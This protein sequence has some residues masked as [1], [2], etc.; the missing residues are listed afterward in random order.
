MI[1]QPIT[2]ALGVL[3]C[4]TS[5]V[6]QDYPV[7]AVAA[8]KVQLRDMFWAPR[9]ET[10]RGV[11]IPATFHKNEE[12]GRVRNFEIAAGTAHGNVCTVF[13]FDDTDLYKTIEGVAYFLQRSPNAALVQMVEEWIRLIGEAQEPDGYLYTWRTIAERQQAAGNPD[14]PL[15][16]NAFTDWLGSARWEKEDELSHELYNAG[17][18]YEAAVAWFQATGQRTL[19]DIAL[20]N[21][22]LLY[23]TFGPQKLQKAPGHEVVEM[24]LVQL[25]RA[26]GDRRWLALSKFFIDVRGYGEEYAQNHLPVAQQRSAVGHAVRL[27]YL[28]SGVADIKALTGTTAYDDALWAVWEDIVQR[29]IYLTGG[30]GATGRNEGFGSPYELPNLSAYCETCSSI[31]F[32]QWTQ[33]L[34]QLTGDARYVDVLERTMY[35]A[36]NA[37]LSL[38]GDYFFYPNPLESRK[39]VARSQ[40]F[41]CACCPPNLIRFFGSLP[42]YMYAVDSS[43]IYVNLY[44]A[45]KVKTGL[46]GTSSGADSVTI[47]QTTAFPRDGEISLSMELSRSREFSLRLRI[48][49]WAAEEAIPGNLYQFTAPLREKVA[50]KVNGQSFSTSLHK[51]YIEIRRRWKKGDQVWLS[52]PMPVRRVVADT[53]VAADRGRVAL[54]RGPLVYCL[55]GKD[56]P[57]DRVQ[58]VFLSDTAH[59]Q[60]HYEGG[61]LGGVTALSMP[62][63]LVHQD[64]ETAIRLEPQTLKAIPYFT[65]ANRGRDNMLVW[66]PNVL[67]ATRPL[68]PPTLASRSVPTASE[69]VHGDLKNTSDGFQPAHA[70][71]GESTLVHWWPRFGTEEWLEYDLGKE[72]TI[73]QAQVFWFDDEATG[74]GC[75]IPVWWKLEYLDGESWKPVAPDTSFIVRKDAWSDISF[76]PIQTRRLRL[77]MQWQPGV[78]GG[79]H[80]WQIH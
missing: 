59:V 74:G 57:D 20:K 53:R 54:Q 75:R 27:A 18:L 64:G 3:L 36:L 80:E 1:K 43:G 38:S 25:Y 12:T 48:P 22:E 47:T 58:S 6:A 77:R 35:N 34:F 39:N 70:A 15:K 68:A 46:L 28:Y 65:W 73:Q 49:G 50:V 56:Q 30:T 60:V 21:A 72:E 2:Y 67:S 62:G 29:Q 32:V 19:L 40:W 26:T 24:G 8:E 78:S 16:S 5:L 55:E 4:S 23:Q 44:G 79:V 63:F 41:E 11:T 10:V 31:A 71:D 37:G 69:G 7:Q 17:H 61:L 66:L 42:G 13:P 52:L 33:R 51:G 45:S 76:A 9:L 14:K